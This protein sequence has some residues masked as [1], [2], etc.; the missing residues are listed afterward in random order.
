MDEAT[1][2]I[3]RKQAQQP[4]D[5]QYNSDRIKHGVSPFYRSLDQDFSL[6]ECWPLHCSV[7]H[8]MMW[9]Q[10]RPT[11]WEGYLPRFESGLPENVEFGQ[12][13]GLTVVVSVTLLAIDD[14]PSQASFAGWRIKD[15]GI[16]LIAQV[17]ACRASWKVLTALPSTCAKYPALMTS[18]NLLSAILENPKRKCREKTSRIIDCHYQRLIR[19][20]HLRSPLSGWPPPGRSRWLV[21]S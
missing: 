15:S 1:G 8:T 2:G 11:I 20:C 12:F 9:L 6:G 17:P 16:I 13:F 19:L 4:Q 5:N 18:V 21:E 14:R 10:R 7:A 3:G